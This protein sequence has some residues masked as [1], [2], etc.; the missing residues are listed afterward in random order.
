MT[1]EA[2]H[3][4]NKKIHHSSM[5]LSARSYYGIEYDVKYNNAKSKNL[6]EDLGIHAKPGSIRKKTT[7]GVPLAIISTCYMVENLHKEEIELEI[8][9]FHSRQFSGLPQ[10]TIY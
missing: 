8:S 2:D 7:I 4:A 6:Q 1:P 9:F 3:S 5:L 10:A